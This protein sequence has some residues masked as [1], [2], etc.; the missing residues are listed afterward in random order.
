MRAESGNHD[1]HDGAEHHLD[2]D[3][4]VDIDDLNHNIG[5]ANEAK[6][7]AFREVGCQ[8]YCDICATC[9]PG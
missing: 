6:D 5:R 1:H 4:H 2:V 7:I 9:A 8:Y 3:H